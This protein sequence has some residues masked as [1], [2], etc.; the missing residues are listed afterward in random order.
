MS[1]QSAPV[2]SAPR[3]RAS[4]ASNFEL[5]T[6]LFMRGSGLLLVVL[7]ITIPLVRSVG[8]SSTTNTFFTLMVLPALPGSVHR[9]LSHRGQQAVLVREVPVRRTP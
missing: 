7:V 6:W 1:P 3:T 5:N 4:K 2:L 8:E 9:M